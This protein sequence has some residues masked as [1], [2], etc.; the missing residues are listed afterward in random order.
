MQGSEHSEKCW[1]LAGEQR[2]S[3]RQNMNRLLIELHHHEQRSTQ[4][5]T[6]STMLASAP[7]PFR[8]S[9]RTA[10]RVRTTRISHPPPGIHCVY[11][12]RPYGLAP[13]LASATRP[14]S[15]L[16]FVLSSVETGGWR[17]AADY[18]PASCKPLTRTTHQVLTH[19]I[20]HQHARNGVVLKGEVFNSRRASR[21]RRAH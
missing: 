9:Q 6:R 19:M 5:Y 10:C 16:P 8:H 21:Q 15:A 3:K 14:C 4:T 7:P 1:S 13:R 11:L 17:T 12:I 18:P 2:E 20:V